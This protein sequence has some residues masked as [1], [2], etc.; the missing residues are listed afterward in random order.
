MQGAVVDTAP[1]VVTF[2][3]IDVFMEREASADAR[4]EYTMSLMDTVYTDIDSV[5]APMP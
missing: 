3:D 2:E 4:L 1:E 5:I